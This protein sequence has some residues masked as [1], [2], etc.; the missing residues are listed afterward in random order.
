[1]K[2]YAPILSGTVLATAFVTIHSAALNP[3]IN[4]HILIPLKAQD[5]LLPLSY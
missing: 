1:M 2:E 5:V 3:L 4:Q